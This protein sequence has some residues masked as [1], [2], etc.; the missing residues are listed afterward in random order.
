MERAKKVH[1]MGDFPSAVFFAQQSVEK[2]VK[3]MIESRGEYIY[4][5]G[6]RL[7]NEFLKIFQDE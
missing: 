1:G 3:A 2:A 4:N 7:A 6:P 5:Y